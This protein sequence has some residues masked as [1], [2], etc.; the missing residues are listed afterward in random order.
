MR[1]HEMQ[2]VLDQTIKDLQPKISDV[3]LADN[4]LGVQFTSL[5]AYR[6]AAEKVSQLPPLR[7]SA[8]TVLGQA[9]LSNDIRDQISIQTPTAQPIVA[10]MNMLHLEATL[11]LSLIN[12]T[13]TKETETSI[14]ILLPDTNDIS[15]LGELVAMVAEYFKQF[16]GL[17]VGDDDERVETIELSGFDVGSSWLMVNA[18]KPV[19][20]KLIGLAWRF[21]LAVFVDRRR[22][23]AEAAMV[24]AAAADSADV[25]KHNRALR[26]TFRRKMAERLRD[27]GAKKANNEEINRLAAV[28]E[29]GEKLL[30]RRIAL[31]ASTKAPDEI[32]MAFPPP[33]LPPKSDLEKLL[34]E[35]EDMANKLLTIGGDDDDGEV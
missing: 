35:V 27:A 28:I 33:E 32:R 6:R 12:A 7:A 31:M 5:G 8:E 21:S 17:P 30:T 13:V 19:V 2:N 11:L 1:L 22:R 20:A 15:Q 4:V 34:P 29:K 10:M 26:K 14:A 24:E 25:A 18:I 9:P 23:L 16:E 3:R